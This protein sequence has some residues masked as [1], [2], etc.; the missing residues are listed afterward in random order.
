MQYATRASTEKTVRHNA[1]VGEDPRSVTTSRGV[2]VTLA[3]GE[4]RVMTTSTSVTV[5]RVQ[6]TTRS[7]STHQGPSGVIVF[8]GSKT[9]QE[10][11]KVYI[12]L[13]FIMEGNK[14]QLHLKI[15]VTFS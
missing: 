15:S 5:V 7:A 6:G 12:I 14:A 2:Y 13:A 9:V 10:L 3:G 4:R 11:V 8:P 1:D